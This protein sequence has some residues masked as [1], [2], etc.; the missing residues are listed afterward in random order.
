MDAA[1]SIGFGGYLAGQWF[2]GLWLSEQTI[3]KKTV[4]RSF[5]KSFSQFILP[6]VSGVP[7]GQLNALCFSATTSLSFKS[8]IKRRQKVL[9]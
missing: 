8:F 2:Q 4:F 7:S 6:A 9:R 3:N 1:G 5:G